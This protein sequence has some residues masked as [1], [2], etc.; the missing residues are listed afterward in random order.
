V[1]GGGESLARL[2]VHNPELIRN[3]RSG[4]RPL[5]AILLGVAVLGA[6]SFNLIVNFAAQMPPRYLQRN[7]TPEEIAEALTISFFI[8]LSVQLFLVQLGGL[9][10][11][12]ASVAG[13]RELKTWDVQRMSPASALS[14]ASGKLIGAPAVVWLMVIAAL[15]A[16]ALCV[17]GGGVSLNTL[18]QGA[19]LVVSGS[20]L[21]GSLGLA[22]SSG[23]ENRRNATVTAFL[24]AVIF[25][26]FSL[27]GLGASEAWPLA[28][29][30]PGIVIF[31]MTGE[32]ARQFAPPLFRAG[33]FFGLET[34]MVWPSIVWECAVS[35]AFIA[36][37]M[38]LMRDRETTLWSKRQAYIIYGVV[39]LVCTGSCWPWALGLAWL[40][41]TT[42]VV[43][44]VSMCVVALIM[45]FAITPPHA[46][47][48]D[49]LRHAPAGGRDPR[50][51]LW[52]ERSPAL[53]AMGVVWVILACVLAVT[54]GLW[55]AIGASLA[56]ALGLF[57]A[58]LLLAI[59]AT[60]VRKNG[61]VLAFGIMFA[62][63]FCSG[64]FAAVVDSEEVAEACI[65]FFLA[66]AVMSEGYDDAVL[67]SLM[68]GTVLW[69]FVALV[70][71]A[72]WR[73]Q[74]ARLRRVASRRAGG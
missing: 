13:E 9:L 36:G 51:W 68:G 20:L 61:K 58:A 32:A 41:S 73:G 42:A 22:F 70:M 54:A 21:Y 67:A 48:R 29:L 26:A 5:K 69:G 63:C 57:P 45:A 27:V 18:A 11:A 23:V 35:A 14:M 56:A 50:D 30:N 7:I 3:L 62:W 10:L 64:I 47:A 65:P 24:A 66:G 28:G 44:A 71:V 52:G 72:T 12:A 16:Q 2:L 15:P 39:G 8:C 4:L 59:C 31:G 33:R 53:L 25:G 40:K 55:R 6:C 19:A 1:A 17:M 37:A 38:R 46:K 74:I 49:W 60:A 43:L 34:G